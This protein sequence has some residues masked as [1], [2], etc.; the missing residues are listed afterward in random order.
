VDRPS[1]ACNTIHCRSIVAGSTP[2]QRLNEKRTS[3]PGY[4]PEHGCFKDAF[5]ASAASLSDNTL[6][7]ILVSAISVIAWA[8]NHLQANTLLG[9]CFEVGI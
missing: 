2:K 6:A 8:R 4:G 5:S 7:V 1:V 3:N 9:F